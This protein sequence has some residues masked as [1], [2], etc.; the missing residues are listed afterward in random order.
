[1]SMNDTPNLRFSKGLLLGLFAVT[2]LALA[3]G[4]YGFYRQ[5][6]QAIRSDKYTELK[7]ISELKV[8]QIV[9]WRNERLSD[10]RL[11]SSGILRTLA[12][13]WLKAP[14][15]DSLKAN[16]LARLKVFRDEEGYRNMILASP[17]GRLLL[18]L[19]TRLTQLEAQAKELVAQAVASRGAVFGDFFLCSVRD[20]VHLDVAA[21]ILDE[22][23]RPVAALLLRADPKDFL[24]PLVQSWPTPSKSAETLLIRKDNNNVLFLNTLRH[25]PDPVLTLRIPL[26]CSN[27]PAVQAALDKIG[28]FEGKDY[29]GVDVVSDLR[30]VAGS[31]WFMVAKVDTSEILAEARYRGEVIM[32]LV[33]LS[34]LMSG[35]LLGFLFYFGQAKLYQELFR[36]TRFDSTAGAP[37]VSV[38]V[39]VARRLSMAA[40]TVTIAVGGVVLVG[41]LFD[42]PSLKSVLPDFV[43]MK[44]NTAVGFVFAGLSLALLGRAARFERIRGLSQACAGAT[45]LLGLLT[46]SQYLFG[47]DFGIDQLLFRE[48]AG[49]V[50][51]L[52][53]GRMAP[54]T[55][56]N[57]LLL[58][59]AL[60][61]A[62]FR[63]AI[64]TAQWLSL[65][66]GLM[67]LLPLLGYLYGAPNLYGI[68]HYT[69][70][71]VHTALTFIILSLGVLLAHP[72][73]GPMRTVTDDTLGGW[74][75][76]RIAPFVVGGPLVL[77]WLRVRGEQNGYFESALGVALMIVVTL[78]LTAGV[79]WW[80]VRVLNRIDAV[81]RQAESRLVESEERYRILFECSRDALMVLAP[82]SWK[83]TSVNPATVEL[84]GAKDAAELAT[85]GPWAL[86]PEIQP[87]GRPSDE[88][89]K[90]MIETALR[91]GSC[92]FEWTHKRLNG[93][94]FP[95]M[96]LLTRMELAGRALLQAT[97]R[98]ITERKRVDEQAQAAADETRRL[99]EESVQSRRTLLSVVE[100]QKR[101]EEEV[102]RLNDELEQ[103][104]RRRTAQLEVANKELEAFSYSVSH[105]LR[106]PL[107]TIAGF[108]QTLVEDY[109]EKLGGEA[110]TDLARIRA[111]A[112]KMSQ[113]I[114][115]M[116]ALSRL[117]RREMKI[118]TVD[119]SGLVKEITEEL[120]KRYPGQKNDFVIAEGLRVQGDGPL[121][122]IVL[123]NLLENS[124]KFTRNT[125]GARIEFGVAD[126][127]TL[128]ISSSAIRLPPFDSAQ[129]KPSPV[130]Y[131]RDNGAGFDMAYVD[132]LFK[133]FERLH[134]GERV[135]GVRDR[136]G[137]REENH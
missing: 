85:L 110:K 71:A 12:L 125:S 101:A 118:G 62:G 89:A 23:Q 1:M 112:Q 82:P 15:D 65:L 64:P 40:A 3:A 133:P 79:I 91:E 96:V 60:S 73:D 127:S 115:S 122:R 8:R 32:G 66:A 97:V 123:R 11:N 70:M 77:G 54:A 16:I 22:E 26:S 46:L 67:G 111:A 43:T 81:R 137:N 90:E 30:P 132:K 135:C 94:V 74:L 35:F 27:M 36:A 41:W 37:A 38:A 58:G 4:G 83:F 126:P 86:S 68:G 124:M 14:G 53:P 108:S 107:R 39:R 45:A 20:Q 25:R 13:Q 6:A 61:L 17:D 99:L 34:I 44:A 42:I 59:C 119:L 31:P 134:Q 121:L 114:D 33:V 2:A 9:A 104:V 10:A 136:A 49:A 48:P 50:G 87:D 100:D 63:R 98:D 88:K 5:E 18:S 106:T 57:F 92:S 29:R 80:I 95:A 78:L 76:R 28:V 129:G 105:D 116:L 93:K 55:A 72:M 84:F 117:S 56:I 21:P 102:R 131:I 47:L 69:Q 24:Y 7:A 109:G 51:T 130:Y 52:S 120:G 75:L 113:L 19:D 103:R 128:Q